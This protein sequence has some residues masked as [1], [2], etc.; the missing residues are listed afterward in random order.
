LTQGP[1]QALN[2]LANVYFHIP[3]PQKQANP[4]GGLLS[5]LLGG[6]GGVGVQKR[7]MTPPRTPDLD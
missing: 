2:E 4:F 5:G 7:V 6:P 3:I 1:C